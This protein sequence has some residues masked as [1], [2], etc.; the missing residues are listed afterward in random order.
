MDTTSITAPTKC[1][2]PWLYLIRIMN[3]RLVTIKILMIQPNS[4]K[5]NS[6]CQYTIHL[7]AFGK[8]HQYFQ[9]KARS[10]MSKG[11]DFNKLKDVIIDAGTELIT[12]VI[13]S[14]CYENQ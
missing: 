4:N 13:S 7:L 8:P 1:S 10:E 3:D 5:L 2:Q 11:V 6:S 14:R 9:I 12:K